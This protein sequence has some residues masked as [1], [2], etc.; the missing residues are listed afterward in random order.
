MAPVQ[1]HKRIGEG[2]RGPNTGGMGAY[3]PPPIV[4]AE[5]QEVI[6]RTVVE[7]TLKGMK[8]EGAP[9]RGVLFVGLMIADG[10]PMV[11]EYNVRFGDPECQAIMSRWSG[12]FLPLLE[13]AARGDLSGVEGSWEAPCALCV[14]LASEG[15]PGAYPKGRVISGLDKVMNHE[16]V[17]VFHAGTRIGDDGYETSGGR[18]MAVAAIG[19]SV[20]RCAE[21]AYAAADC[22][23]FEGKQLRRDIGHHAR[24]SWG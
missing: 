9:F 16:G 2:D 12:P 11:L 6:L 24:K 1:D 23:E 8:E 15:Y 7:P 19:D 3:S 13:G 10:N 20:E 14:V 21:R 18:V 4:D 5:L 22:I 17:Q